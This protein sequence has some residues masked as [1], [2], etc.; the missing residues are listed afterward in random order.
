M[1]FS[2]LTA[3]FVKIFQASFTWTSVTTKSRLFQNTSVHWWTWRSSDWTTTCW[4]HWSQKFAACACLKNWVCPETSW[5]SYLFK[6]ITWLRWKSL[7]SQITSSKPCLTASASTAYTY[8]ASW[9]MEICSHRFLVHFYTC[10]SCKNLELSGSC[11][12]NRPS[13]S[14]LSAARL[15]A[16]SSLTRYTSCAHY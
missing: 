3:F 10:K 8:R 15:R 9:S 13:Q 14:W 12:Q 5:L 2:K 1:T 4:A 7:T 6:L 16:K 11:T